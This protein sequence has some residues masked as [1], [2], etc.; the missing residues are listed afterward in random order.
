MLG[1][2]VLALVVQRH[3][4]DDL[5]LGRE[6]GQHVGLQAPDEAAAAQVPVDPLLG[7]HALEAPREARAAAEVL[8]PAEHP[9]LRDQLL[10]VVHHRRAG[11]RQPQRVRAQRLGQPPHG[12][13]PLGARVLDVVRLVEHQ[14]RRPPQRQPR[15]VR[16]HDVVVDDRDLGRLGDRAGAR[17]DRHRPVRQPVLDLPAPVELQRRRADDDGREGVVGLEGR[18]RLHGL[19]QPLLVRQEGAPR[20]ERVGHAGPL[21]R[22]QLAAQPRLDLQRRPVVRPRAPHAV[23]RLLVLGPQAIEHLAGIRRRLD[24]VDPQVVLERLEQ[25]RVDGQRATVRLAGRKRQERRDRLGVPVDVE[26]EARLADAL[27]EGQGRGRRLLP[28]LQAG[29]AP[30]R[31][32]VEPRARH[33]EQLL[34]HRLRERHPRPSA[35]L[36]GDARQALGRIAGDLVHREAPLAGELARAH[37]A[38]P[39]LDRPRQPGLDVGRDRELRE[40]LEHALDVGRR[41]VRPWGPPLL[42]LPVESPPGHGA[43]RVHDVGP[44]REREDDG[45]LPVEIE[46]QLDVVTRLDDAH[47]NLQR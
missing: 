6:L 11:Q 31:A 36:D 3:R 1:L 33:L 46:P 17:H 9:Q 13:R 20:V 27:D 15:A 7:A 28:H 40:P 25:V 34:G 18:E 45:L 47:A 42:G 30:Q 19:A 8:E 21:E 5:A 16:V 14:R 23:D 37:P 2:T 35:R 4:H 38:D 26:R 24:P 22:P 41:R 43:H 10:G 39:A 32:R 29:R 12:L 44:V